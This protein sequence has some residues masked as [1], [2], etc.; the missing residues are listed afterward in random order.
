[1][2]ASHFAMLSLTL[3]PPFQGFFAA[4]GRKPIRLI[5]DIFIHKVQ[6]V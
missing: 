6:Y 3:S 5:Q 2:I 4:A 1:M